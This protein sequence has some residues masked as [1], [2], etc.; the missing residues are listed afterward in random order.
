MPFHQRYMPTKEKY[1]KPKYIDK[2]IELAEKLSKDL[3]FV[4][5]DFYYSNEN[6]YFGELTFFPGAGL[7]KYYPSEYDE[8]VGKMLKLPPKK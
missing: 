7:S 4:R 5:V 8:I 2:I 1:K 3:P 6:I